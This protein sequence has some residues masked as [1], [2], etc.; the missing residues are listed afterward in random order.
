MR[1]MV[2]SPRKVGTPE[3]K[4]SLDLEDRARK[5]AVAA[6]A[7]LRLAWLSRSH[8][9]GPISHQGRHSI[10]FAGHIRPSI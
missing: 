9:A 3:T 8:H 5:V 7:M 4:D 6:L 1:T 10:V 2:G